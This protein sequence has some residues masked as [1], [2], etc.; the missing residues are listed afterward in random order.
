MLEMAWLTKLKGSPKNS[1]PVNNY[2]TI[3]TTLEEILEKDS[4]QNTLS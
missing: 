4:L 1:F 3:I 2:Y